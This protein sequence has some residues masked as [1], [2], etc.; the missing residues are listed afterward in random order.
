MTLVQHK[1]LKPEW[2][3]PPADLN[4]LR[5]GLWPRNAG[6]T[7]E[8]VLH[9]GGITVAELAQQYGTPLY[10]FDED[11]FRAQCARF[12]T[13]FAGFDVYYAAKA[14]LCR[15]V[16][17][18][19]DEAGLSLDVC[20]GGEL[21][22][23]LA[24]GFPPGRILMHGNNKSPAELE[25]ALRHGVGRV[26]L[27]SFEEIEMLTALA[28]AADHRPAVLIRVRVGVAANT[29]EHIA[30]AHEDQKFGFGLAD[31][32]AAEAARRIRREGVLDLVGLHSHIGS[33][34]FDLGG[35]ALAAKRGLQLRADLMREHGVLPGELN[36]GGG[37]GIAYTAADSAPAPEDFADHLRSVVADSCERSRLPAPRLAVEPGRALV[38]PSGCTLYRVGNV[39]RLEGLRTYV[40]VDGGMSDNVRPALYGG[41]YSAQ[42]AGRRSDA[43]P[44]LS[45]VVGKHC[46]AG[47]VVVRDDYLPADLRAGDLIAVPGTGAYCRSLS[48]NY[49][50]VPR[51]PVIAIRDGRARVLIR[52]ESIEDLMRLEVD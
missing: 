11:D 32:A 30:T 36:L 27:D 23:A 46:D 45:R 17:R 28:R 3:E 24:A 22:M 40:A 10:L 1:P 19:V 2:L 50:Q 37:L 9:I 16:A 39:K 4:A 7:G 29:H 26:V 52:R 14:F 43:G 15:A 42:L 12:R 41:I 8:G 5:P 49:N 47:D 6:Q 33:Q 21:A 38:G 25:A 31:G 34:I 35:F 20:T 13:A 48:H 44:M 51:P 18:M